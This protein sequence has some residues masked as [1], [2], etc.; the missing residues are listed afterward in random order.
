M[1]SPFCGY[2][3]IL[4]RNKFDVD[5]G[6]GV[7]SLRLSCARISSLGLEDKPDTIQHLRITFF[8]ALYGP[9]IECV[10]I[11]SYLKGC[12]LLPPAPVGNLQVELVPAEI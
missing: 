4:V 7:V 12:A 1:C 6:V 8:I 3:L 11:C 9:F 10:V 5:V 2:I